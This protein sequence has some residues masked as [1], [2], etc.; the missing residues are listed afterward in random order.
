MLV[1]T[2]IALL[3]F[4]LLFGQFTSSAF[5][6]NQTTGSIAG[7]VKDQNGALLA[8]A[9]VKVSNKATGEKRNVVT[10]NEGSYAVPLLAPGTYSVRVGYSGFADAVFETVQVA[11]TE[12]TRVNAELAVAGPDAQSVLSDPLIHEDGPGLGRVVDSRAV[13]GLPLATRNFTQILAL[14]PGTVVSLPDN[15]ALGRNSQNV[16]VNGARVTQNNFEING[17]DANNLATNAASLVAVPAPESIQEFKV[18]T[19]LY[20]AV[21]GRGGGGSIQA[22]TKSGGNNFHG[23]AY[24]YFRNASLNANNPFLKAAGVRR[25]TLDRNVFG[26]VLGGPISPDKLFFFVS[27]QRTRESNGASPNSLTSNVF[28]APGLTDDRSQ[29][30]LLTTFNPRISPTSPVATSIHP[31]ALALLNT[32]L[33]EG[34]FLI[35]TPRPDG[36]FSGTSLSTY[37]EDQFNANIDYRLSKNDWLAGRVFFSNAPQFFA[38]PTNGANVPGFGADQEQNNRLFSLQHVRTINAKTINEARAGY[39]FIRA[40]TVGQIPLNDSAVGITRANAA[41]YP[42]L[43]II[44]I[45]PDGTNAVAIGNAGT[46]VDTGNAQ[47]STT[48]TDILSVIRGRHNIRTGASFIFY[49]NDLVA[50]NNRRGTITFRDFNNFLLGRAASS[51]YGDGIGTRNLKAADYSFFVQDD[52]RVFA[53]VNL[54][55]GLRYELDLPPFET[56]GAMSTFDPALYRPRMALDSSGNPVGPPIGGFV[57]AGN[58][59]PQYDLA[60]IPNVGK[61]I[62]TGIDKNNFGPRVGFAYSIFKT[63]RLVARGGYGIYFSRPSNAYIGISINAPPMYTIRR[64]PTGAVVPLSTPF[65]PLPPQS[66]FPA[67]VTGVDLTGQVFDRGLRTAYIQQYNGGVQ[68]SLSKNL[69]LEAAYVG[70]R[71]INL[72]RDIAINQA[73]LASPQ[74]PIFNPVT[75]EVITTNT[76]A[77]VA[78]RAP[79]QGVAVGNFLQI[80]STAQSSY[81]SMQ[82]SLTRRLSK[83]LQFLASYTYGKSLDNASGG[84]DSTGEA[85]DTINIAGDQTN[86]RANRGVSDFDRTHRFAFSYLYDL[87]RPGFAARS[88]A[89]RWVLS[90]WQLA[91]IVTIMSGLPID[92][93]DGGAGSFYGLSGGNNGLMRPSWAPGATVSTATHNVPAGYFFN[94]SAFARPVVLQGRIIPSS[95]GTATAGAT[96]TD[97]GNVGRNVLRGPGQKNMDL[98][99]IRR[100]PIS[101]S[102]NIELRAEFF[103]LFN[104]SNFANPISNLSAVPATSVDPVTG[105]ITGDPGD[106]GRILSTSSNP[107]LIQLAVKFNF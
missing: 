49:R 32:R 102:R 5:A 106:F 78:R 76:P 63:G 12:T 84:S 104:I 50:N 61:R 46:N 26:G 28:I 79:F 17:I 91:G 11:V 8:S 55:L 89:A 16:A 43:G 82:I 7:S 94:P 10:D 45:G 57:Q 105:Q 74:N 39:N 71:G 34:Q 23:A 35:P 42:G 80:Q 66:Q 59:I 25:P 60:E 20:A 69:L 21:Y 81:N 6:Q 4:G 58:V 40:D 22:I 85:R 3:S 31:V 101:E 83:G 96:G 47:S 44:R 18:Q 70:S 62:L 107:R 75:G 98:A 88:T 24:E 68:Y 99:V 36:R 93:V 41:A 86:N 54:N 100:F 72:I 37:R 64:S 92:I 97:F 13:S 90:N 77:N 27:Y 52:W 67:I 48:L 9:E 15:T 73:R 87:P 29:Q 1:K 103:N 56:S 38:L 53:R 30:T 65:F 14:S 19:S 95:N 2:C 51:V 33:S